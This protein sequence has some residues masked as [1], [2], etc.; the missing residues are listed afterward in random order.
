VTL[1]LNF[2]MT[3][4]DNTR[5]DLIA[6]LFTD[7]AEANSPRYCL[8]KPPDAVG[9]EDGVDHLDCIRSPDA[10]HGDGSP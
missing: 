5:H 7:P 9:A 3:S 1:Q 6:G 8:T 2:G 4:R 10:D